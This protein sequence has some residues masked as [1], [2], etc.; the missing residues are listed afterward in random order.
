MVSEA[1]FPRR[2]AA[3]TRK[4]DWA[5]YRAGVGIGILSWLVFAIVDDPIGIT[6]AL[7]ADAGYVAMAF[8]GAD[9]VA[10]NSYWKAFPPALGYGALFLVGVILGGMAAAVAGGRFRI[11]AVPGIWRARFGASIAKRLSGALLGGLFVMYGARLAG[12]CTSGHTISGGLQLALSSW[13]FT[14]VI[15][16][17]G[18]ATARVLYGKGN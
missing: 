7:S 8:F 2:A 13:I 14:V 12:G 11:E 15:F 16:A 4:I 1:Q 6:T 5:P 17:V 18:I 10:Q 3:G 9:A